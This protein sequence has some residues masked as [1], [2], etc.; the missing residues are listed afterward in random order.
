VPPE[1]SIEIS[2]VT[3]VLCAD[4]DDF[5]PFADR[6]APAIAWC[7]DGGRPRLGPRDRWIS[8]NGAAG[9]W[10]H[11]PLP[12]AD[13]RFAPGSAGAGRPYWLGE[14]SERRAELIS[15]YPALDAVGTEG[16]VAV[17]LNDADPARVEHRAFEAL[18]AGRLLVSET[19]SPGR[20]LE[21]G[22]DYLEV[23]APDELYTAVQTVSRL[24]LAFERMR[25][26][27][28]AKA[29]WVRASDLM[30]RAAGDL[31]LELGNR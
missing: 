15:A 10:R 5:E 9:A 22:L 17:N 24:P 29:E 12:V 28:R 3:V 30:A 14:P 4:A 31:L 16:D 20:G 7:A 8:A 19:L 25:L 18:A 23:R 6:A 2:G 26:R 11:L 27:G 13:D 21:P 1:A